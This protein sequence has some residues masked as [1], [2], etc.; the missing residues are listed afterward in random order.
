MNNTDYAAGHRAGATSMRWDCMNLLRNSAKKARAVGETMRAADCEMHATDIE[1][2]PLP[3]PTEQVTQDDA[4]LARAL[5]ELA[6]RWEKI[7]SHFTDDQN[8]ALSPM[9]GTLTG[10]AIELRAL[11]ARLSGR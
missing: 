11:A 8:V 6:D 9:R 3:A 2:L 1:M 5:I 10:C 7:G 4:E